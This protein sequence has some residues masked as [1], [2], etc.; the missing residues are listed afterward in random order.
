MRCAIARRTPTCASTCRRSQGRPRDTA[1]MTKLFRFADWPLRAK[2]AALLVAV[3]LLP[4]AVWAYIDLQQDRARL[5]R[6]MQDLLGAR[7]DQIAREVDGFHRG[8]RRAVEQIARFP[9]SSAYCADTSEGRAARHDALLGTLAAYPASDS[10][11][12]GAALLDGKGRVV[13]ATEKSLTGMDLADRPVVRAAL[14]G[15]PLV[16]DPFISSPASGSVPTIAYMA[17]TLDPEGKVSCIAVLWLRATSL[18]SAVK[19]SNALAG[20]G[21]F[22]VLFDRDG[23]RVAHTYSDDLVFR[24]GGPLEAATLERLVAERRFGLR[25]RAL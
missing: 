5:L 9:D 22:A 10:G 15:R 19:T 4:I 6:A 24:P 2:M 14:Q 17:P 1:R 13:I 7:G 21:S 12:R 11:I 18:W 25:T 16:S 8:Y 23:I 20:P 3:S